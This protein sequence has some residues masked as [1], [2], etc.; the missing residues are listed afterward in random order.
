MRPHLEDLFPQ[1]AGVRLDYAWGGTLAITRSRLP[2]LARPAP[3]VLAAGGYS[4]Q[5]VALATL[6]G[7]LM[8]DAIAGDGAGFDAFAALPHR[9]FPGGA[10]LRWPLLALGMSW[11]ALRDRLGV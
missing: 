1:L 3:N 8:A 9:R 4:G 7:K 10:H 11:F 5:G 6:A 2:H